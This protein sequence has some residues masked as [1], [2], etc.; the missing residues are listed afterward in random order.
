MKTIQAGDVK[1]GHGEGLCVI[2]G[3][4]T[5][6]SYDLCMTIGEAV[7]TKCDSLEMGYIFKASFDKA[8]RSSI[9]TPRGMGIDEGLRQLEKIGVAL[10]VPTTTDVHESYQAAQVGG[11]V[12]VIQIPAFLCRQTD[13]LVAAAKT[14]KVVNVKKGQF[15]SPAEMENVVNKLSESGAD[16]SGIMLTERGTFFGYNRLVND[17][18]GLGDMME[19]GWPVCFDVTHSTQQPGGEGNASGGRPERAPLLAKCAVA[20]G[21]QA[22]FIETH[23]DPSHAMSDGATMLPLERSLGLLDE[24]ARLRAAI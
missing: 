9:H 21:V 2:A 10:G 4:C 23:T 24:L 6:E 11:V 19:Y 13:L 3:P 12:D 18:V 20:A 5:L 15:L 22:V 1:I 16:Q 8:N 17:F 14:G 7:K